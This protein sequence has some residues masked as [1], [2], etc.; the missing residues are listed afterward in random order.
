MTDGFALAEPVEHGIEG[1]IV[2]V[3]QQLLDER[4]QALM[5]V[6]TFDT[7][8]GLGQTSGEPA[9]LSHLAR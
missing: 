1:L 8:A 7:A 9:E 2:F 4:L 3:R 5:P 6:R